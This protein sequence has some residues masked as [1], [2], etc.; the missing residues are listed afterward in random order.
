VNTT[1]TNTISWPGAPH[2]VGK[3]RVYI[4]RVVSK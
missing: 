3:N 4:E 1:F 2:P